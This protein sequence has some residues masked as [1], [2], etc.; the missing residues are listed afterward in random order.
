MGKRAKANEPKIHCAYQKLVQLGDLKPYPR[1]RN[2]HTPEQ[3]ERLAKL[4]KYQGIRA[5]IVCTDELVIAKGHGTLEA[6]KLNGWK[7]APVVIQEFKD[8]DQ[9]Y[10]FVQSDNSI[11][12]WA[13]LDLSGINADLPDLGPEFDL[14]LLGI[15][16]FILE[17]ADHDLD[18]K[19]PKQNEE[20][21]YLLEIEFSNEKESIALYD[22]L[23]SRGLIV[24]YK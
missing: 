16:D 10:A 4:L 5:P 17:P 19:T 20:G 21:K 9:L 7:K 2:T 15:K 14:D 23:L 18:E 6:I 11:A 24:R 3:I 13:D 1:N 8:E 12:S 22:E